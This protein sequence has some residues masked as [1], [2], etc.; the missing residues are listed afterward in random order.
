MKMSK[1]MNV[2][3][4]LLK[5]HPFCSPWNKEYLNSAFCKAIATKE[6]DSSDGSGEVN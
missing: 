5:Q 1:K 3:F 4:L 6:S 2:V